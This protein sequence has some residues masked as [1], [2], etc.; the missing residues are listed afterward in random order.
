M[1]S[2]FVNVSV[3]YLSGE[4]QSLMF[5]QE[6][7]TFGALL[8]RLSLLLHADQEQFVLSQRIGDEFEIIHPESYESFED[9]SYFYLVVNSPP[10]FTLTHE[11]ELFV[12]RNERDNTECDPMDFPRYGILFCRFVEA[13]RPALLEA[14]GS[15]PRLSQPNVSIYEISEA[16]VRTYLPGWALE[17]MAYTDE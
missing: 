17:R 8:Y 4:I 10:R 1:S 5:P 9:H 15:S 3:Q 12:L 11:N 7:A 6:Q 14:L 13:D 2:A 16:F